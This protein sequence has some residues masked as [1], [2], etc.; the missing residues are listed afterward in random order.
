VRL[1]NEIKKN[2]PEESLFDAEPN[3]WITSEGFLKWLN[4]VDC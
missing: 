3:G 2:I 1:D 4:A